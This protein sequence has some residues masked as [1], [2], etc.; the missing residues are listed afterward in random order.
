M[1]RA[2]ALLRIVTALTSLL[3]GACATP[4]PPAPSAELFAD[5]EFA[6]PR[7][8]IDSA[9]VFALSDAMRR[10]LREDIADQ[11]RVDG[12]KLG[13]VEAL[14][15]KGQLRLEYDA[16][17]TRNAAQTFDARAGNCLSLV[18]M[19]AA[20]ARELD[21]PVRFQLVLSD[22]TWSRSGDL[23]VA[24]GH[25]N[26]VLGR[27]R[28][29]Y[30]VGLEED[31]ETTIDFQPADEAS[32]QRVRSIGE[33][34]VVAMYLNNR[35]AETLAAGNLDEAYWWARAAV[36]ADPRFLNAYNT[37]GVI[38]FRHGNLTQAR[39]VLATALERAPHDTVAIA[40]IVPV[41]DALGENERAREM[42]QRLRVLEPEP[43]FAAFN[44]G[45]AAFHAGDYHKARDLFQ[46]EVTR[47]PW[48]HEFH[49]WL[50]V[51][52]LRLGEPSKAT[53]E[54][55]SAMEN[56]TTRRDYELYAAKLEHLQSTH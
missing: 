26:L 4:P 39:R 34:T 38:Y 47:E 40:N 27:L 19:S 10:Y 12:R 35:A 51:T 53:R 29:R 15:R 23:Y 5:A 31:N 28:S 44:R 17:M 36:H 8:P 52:Y 43:P 2:P 13:L 30:A 9:S 6:P 46:S 3:L 50:G 49:Y 41:L 11:L 42:A 16:A 25:V 1:T 56:S 54:L 37:L 55:Q 18:I 32:R 33:E 7:A 45:L 20:L 48:Y 21:L 22:E 14:Y 24:I